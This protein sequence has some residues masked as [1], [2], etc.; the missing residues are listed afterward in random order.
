MAQAYFLEDEYG[1]KFYTV[2][3]ADATFNRHGQLIGDVLDEISNNVAENLIPFPYY[4]M[5]FSNIKETNGI[6]FIVNS[7]GSITADGTATDDAYYTIRHKTNERFSL[8][9]GT[10]TLSG[11]PIGGSLNTFHMYI[12]DDNHDIAKD[13]GNSCL[14]TVVEKQII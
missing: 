4:D 5:N 12:A 9:A 14:F 1:E 8:P 10:Y 11:C 7:D 6:K 2:G 3:H 13:F